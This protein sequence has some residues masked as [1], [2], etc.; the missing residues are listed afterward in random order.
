[1]TY[2]IGFFTLSPHDKGSSGEGQA[3]SYGTNPAP[4]RQ[5]IPGGDDNFIPNPGFE[6]PIPAKISGVKETPYP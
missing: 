1:M 6:V 5:Y 4:R 3:G 2:D